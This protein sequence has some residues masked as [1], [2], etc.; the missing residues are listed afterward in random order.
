MSGPPGL[1]RA[2]NTPPP[3]GPRGHEAK[4]CAGAGTS[5]RR[6]PPFGARGVSSRCCHAPDLLCHATLSSQKAHSGAWTRR[7]RPAHCPAHSFSGGLV[8]GP[9]SQLVLRGL[10]HDV[11]LW[12]TPPAPSFRGFAKKC[13]KK[14]PKNS[15]KNSKKFPKK[16]KKRSKNFPKNLR[17]FTKR[18]AKNVQ[19]MAKKCPKNVKKN[20]PKIF[21]TG[22][23]I[24]Q[25][26][27][28]KFSKKRGPTENPPWTNQ[29]NSATTDFGLFFGPG[30][31]PG[32]PRTHTTP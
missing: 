14:C 4:A 18:F 29:K 5:F 25:K 8:Q 17:H 12:R 19:K 13:P 26:M 10:A 15:E 20:V 11:R 16:V 31:S 6:R 24:F 3:P 9:A 1:A 21:I 28:T 23:K 30:T 32:H 2:P 27:A 7:R 22:P